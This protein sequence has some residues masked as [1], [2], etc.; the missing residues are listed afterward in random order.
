M[1]ITLAGLLPPE[2]IFPKLRLADKPRL[3]A[4]LSRRAAAA[5]DRPA[6]DI[7]SVLMAREQLGS[8]GVGSGIAVPHARLDGLSQLFGFFARLEKPVDYESIDG[9]P[10]DLVFLLLSPAQ[11]ASDHLSALAAVSR[12][13]RDK[14]VAEAIRATADAARIRGLLIGEGA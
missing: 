6:Q 14:S 10:V 8:T 11:G 7:G 12:R 2:H 13:L 1:A 9:K 3:L 4:D 5:T